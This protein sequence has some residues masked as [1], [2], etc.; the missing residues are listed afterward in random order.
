MNYLSVENL[1]KSYGIKTLFRNISF[2]VDRGQ[3]VALIAGNGTGKSSLLKILVGKDTADSGA[4]TFRKDIKIGYLDQQPEID[5]QK[6][7]LDEVLSSDNA[8]LVA[9]REYEECLLLQ[10]N[11]QLNESKF[12][13][14]Y[15]KMEDLQAWDYESRIKQILFQLKITKLDQKTG[16]LSGG[17]KKRVALAKV[18]SEDPD[19]LILD[20]PT[21]HL[22]FDMIE[23]LEN[24]LSRQSVTLLM[25]THDRYF[26][27]RVCNEIIEL[28]N[29]KLYNYKGNYSYFLEKKDE[30]EFNEQREQ[31]KSRNL[32]RKELEWIRKMPKARTTK[33]KSRIDAFYDLQDKTGNKKV[34]KKLTLDVKMSRIG[35]K[36]LEM[37]KVYKSYEDKVILKGFDYTFKTGERI[38]IAGSNGS[39][40]STFLNII[41]GKEKA[42][43]G[44]INLGETIVVGY[45]SQDGLVLKEDKRVIEVVKDIAEVIPLGDGSKLTASQFLQHFMFPP[46]MQYTY[47]S[48]LSGGE[49]RRLF[50]LTVLIKNP[51][52]LI[53]DEPTND[54]D[55]LTLNALEDFLMNYKGCLLLVS[56][57]RYFMDKL[58]D[59]LF[60]FEGNGVTRDFLGNYSDY[61]EYQTEKEKVEKQQQKSPE[62]KTE[63]KTSDSPKKYTFQQKKE[64]EQLEKEIEKLE[65]KKKEIEEGL[66]SGTL[67]NEAISSQSLELGKVIEDIETKTTRWLELGEIVEI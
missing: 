43:S 37:K 12:Q 45:Y 46:E 22:D 50:M 20:E 64:Y 53:L 36:V 18:L 67:S 63:A 6:T 9:I 3:R 56:H 8:I 39:G 11:G 33:S 60:I 21:N 62:E 44:K 5:E 15:E 14:A 48:K 4:V 52:F 30:R 28:D 41:T 47:V 59:H 13:A 61:R 19:L 42:D 16:E 58:V 54:L 40:K 57:D 35:G 2:G 24:Y 31:D 65:A 66:F 25:V 29:G 1:V 27:D 34:E 55:L 23:W 7:V 26:L 51:N 32:L 17:Q 49:K 38:G 10:E